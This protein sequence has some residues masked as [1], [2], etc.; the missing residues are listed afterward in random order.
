MAVPLA[1]RLGQAME[2]PAERSDARSRRWAH[3]NRVVGHGE[4]LEAPVQIASVLSEDC[5]VINLR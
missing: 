4:C 5:S 2:H 3:D 1:Y